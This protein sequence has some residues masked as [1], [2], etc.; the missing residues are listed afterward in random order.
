MGLRPETCKS[1][2]FRMSKIQNSGL[3]VGLGVQD[4]GLGFR[5]EDQELP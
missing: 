3:R 5:V 4:L 1:A 2:R